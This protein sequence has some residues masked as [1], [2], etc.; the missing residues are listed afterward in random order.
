MDKLEKYR[1]YIQELLTEIGNYKN[2]FP[3]IETQIV[4][5]TTHDHY[6]LVNVGWRGMEMT[7]GVSIHIDI[8]DGKIWIQQ[9]NTDLLIAEDLVEKGVPKS[10]IVLAFHAPYKRKYTDYAA[11]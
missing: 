11:A 7:Y 3:E 4:F 5:D 1:Q 10:D 9:N 8:K 2:H 6:Q